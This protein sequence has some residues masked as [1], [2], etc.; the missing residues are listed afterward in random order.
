[1]FRSYDDDKSGFISQKEFNDV[2]VKCNLHLEVPESDVAIL[3][4]VIDDDRNDAISYEEFCLIFDGRTGEDS[5]LFTPSTA[6]SAAPLRAQSGA[7]PPRLRR[8]GVPLLACKGI[9]I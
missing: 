2:I 4:D 6:S 7:C 3:F 1:M 9:H 8:R 5:A